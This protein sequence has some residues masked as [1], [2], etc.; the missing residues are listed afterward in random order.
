MKCYEP[1]VCLLLS[2][3]RVVCSAH[4]CKYIHICCFWTIY[5]SFPIIG[6]LLLVS[7][8]KTNQLPLFTYH[9]IRHIPCH[10]L[11]NLRPNI[12]LKRHPYLLSWPQNKSRQ[13]TL[14]TGSFFEVGISINQKVSS[15]T[16]QQLHPRNL[17]WNLKVMVTK[18]TFL[19]QDLCSGSMLNFG[20]V[21]FWSISWH[22]FLYRILL[23]EGCEFLQ[24][25]SR[26]FGPE[27]TNGHV[28]PQDPPIGRSLRSSR[29]KILNTL[30]VSLIDFISQHL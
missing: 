6:I 26:I 7:S 11:A 20:A 10:F 3:S 15:S 18:W 19:F 8:V 1:M 5:F 22:L 12:P 29:F 21:R 30:N 27:A 2:K 4:T 17:T 28:D 24:V 13:T 25:H 14:S 23:Q 16:I 9:M